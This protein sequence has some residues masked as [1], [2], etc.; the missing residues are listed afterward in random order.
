M[1][2]KGISYRSV[3]FCAGSVIIIAVT[4]SIRRRLEILLHSIFPI[5]SSVFPLS[6]E[7]IFTASSGAEVPKATIVSPTTSEGIPYLR[8]IFEAQDTRMSAHLMRR[9]NQRKNKI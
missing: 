5:T 1:R 6:A 3:E 7:N 4:Q 8:A 9:G 2:E